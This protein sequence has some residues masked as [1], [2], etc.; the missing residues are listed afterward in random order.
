MRG[1]VITGPRRL[2]VLLLASVVAV[3]GVTLEASVLALPAQAAVTFNVNSFDDRRDTN[4]ADNVCLTSA[5]NCSLRA[6]I[7]QANA[8]AGADTI[9]LQGGTYR[10]GFAGGVQ[11]SAATVDPAEPAG[12]PSS[13]DLDITDSVT[14]LGGATPSGTGSTVNGGRFSS[15]FEV[16]NVS[17]V[18]NIRNLTVT[19]GGEEE[20]SSFGSG[21]GLLIRA[22]S[23][24]LTRVTVRDNVTTEQ[25]SGIANAGRL[26]LLESTV[27]NNRNLSSFGGR[28]VTA[29]GG[30]IH[31]FSTGS[32]TIDR[33][34]ISNNF[35]LRGG[36]ITN[37]FGQMTISN[38]TIS[39]NTAR[40]SGGG[41]LNRGYGTG[42]KGTLNIGFSTIVGN[43]A[44]VSG[45]DDEKLGG[46][47]A[48]AG[49]QVN[50]GGTILAGNTDNRSHFDASFTPDCHSLDTFRFTSFR[51]NVIGLLTGT[52][53]VR[54]TFWGESL[55]FDR[56]GRDP[57]APLDP[58]VGAMA[59]N[60][61]TTTNRPPLSGSPAVDFADS[62]TS[63]ALFNC[64]ATDQRG[65]SR[66]RDGDANGSAACDTGSVE[67][68]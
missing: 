57:A 6:A 19:N 3:V 13:R 24:S 18:V 33:S 23:V 43:Q 36:G 54:D 22:G 46:G 52:C 41:I 29:E 61:G 8:T 25:G 65:V 67:I 16:D 60:G 44:N 5:G 49:G 66:P 55:N 11:Q 32:V 4:L 45:A 50:M 14:I 37:N 47:I 40:N 35:S 21:G 59:H 10:L 7:Q 15:V 68:G 2:G 30:G 1:T 48:N 27:D 63:G 31:N 20:H 42:P 12:R 51:N 9:H 39:G 26:S 64:P 38:S 17:A 34:T 28:G 58:R 56:V 53:V 62:G